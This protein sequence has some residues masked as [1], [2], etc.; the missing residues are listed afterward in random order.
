MG[1]LASYR[2]VFANPALARLMIGEFVSSIGDWLYLV[3][4]LVLVYRAGVS[5][6][7]LGIVGAARIVPYILLSVPAGIAADRYDRRLI[8]IVTDVARGVIMVVLTALAVVDGPIIAI[9][10]L[11]L[12]AAC[13]SAFF[14]PAIGSL[15]PTLVR[16]ESEL[17]PAN[18]AW[19]SLDNLAFIIGPA[20]AAILI[21]VGSIPL[22]FFLNAISFGI[23]AAVLWRL[24]RDPDRGRARE[25][26][27]PEAP[28]PSFRDAV[29]PVIRPLSGLGLINL[30]D[31]FVS[32]GLAVLTVVIA[33]EV[34]GSG[35][36]GTGWLNAAIG[37]GGLI[38]AVLAGPMTLRRRLDIPLAVGGVTLG[39]GVIL[40]GQSGVL[41]AAIA[42]MAVATA[43]MLVLEVVATTIFQREVPDAIRGRTIG[44]M[45]T[46]T[47]SA[48]ALGAFLAPILASILTPV[49]V[50]L[51]FGVAM[52]AAT[53]IG[54]IVVG[55]SAAP[56]LDPGAERFVR[57]PVF[58]GLSPASLEQAAGHLTRI[59][60][61]AGE[62][63]VR[64]GE[65]A[66]R[67]FHVLDGAF[68]VTQVKDPGGAP[69]FLRTLGADD[70]FGEIGLLRAVPR[71]ATVTAAGEG[72]LL[73]LDGHRFL[74]LVSAGPG[75][76]SRLLD[77]HRGAAARLDAPAEE[78]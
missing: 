52:V 44:A 49:V 42:A 51:G 6:V 10:A 40:V 35:D 76:T 41:L 78:G 32:G 69:R 71:T 39:V 53:L 65:P 1:S 11:S 60:V 59:R 56:T 12:L 70:V 61:G 24:P 28:R 55:R 31:G 26:V 13:F 67:F 29:R 48:Y 37:L 54:T 36:A 62:V 23:V 47:V 57:L 22:A 20:V 5:P 72:V 68:E 19:S 58:D 17:G 43:G 25:A 63:V 9:V 18:A 66:D 15:I 14:S 2:R 73:A 16:D 74:E 3:A 21:A 50:L 77:T 46:V 64:Q 45:D 30:V 27:A 38:G 4:L 7:V 33:I 75:L 34:L 8:L